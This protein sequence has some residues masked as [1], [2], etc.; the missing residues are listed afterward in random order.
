MSGRSWT[1]Y[2]YSTMEQVWN[3]LFYPRNAAK[4][5]LTLPIFAAFLGGTDHSRPVP[6]Y[7]GYCVH[8]LSLIHYLYYLHSNSWVVL[9]KK[10]R[11]R[12]HFSSGCWAPFSSSPTKSKDTSLDSQHLKAHLKP[13]VQVQKHFDLIS[14]HIN[15]LHLQPLGTGFFII[16]RWT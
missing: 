13:V 10:L 4:G 16:V 3:R 2:P 12:P 9:C 8:D 15:S 6:E 7:L 5:V 11:H 14:N 1:Q